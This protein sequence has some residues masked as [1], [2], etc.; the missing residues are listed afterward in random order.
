MAYRVPVGVCEEK[1]S[2][3]LEFNLCMISTRGMLINL[4]ISPRLE[5]FFLLCP[6]QNGRECCPLFY[7][8]LQRR[9]LSVVNAFYKLYFIRCMNC[10][11]Y[12]AHI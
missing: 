9:V 12:Y 11:K 3:I 10:A 1:L 4:T 6:A 8:L 5:T 7:P 2:H